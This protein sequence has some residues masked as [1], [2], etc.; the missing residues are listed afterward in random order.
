MKSSHHHHK[1]TA[2]HFL[3]ISSEEASEMKT[4]DTSHLTKPNDRHFE[5]DKK[6][7]KNNEMKHQR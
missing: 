5:N 6:N 7:F 3:A 2:S 1:T 4:K